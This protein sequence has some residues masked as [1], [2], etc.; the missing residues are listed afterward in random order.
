MAVKE[1]TQYHAGKIYP[2]PIETGRSYGLDV[3]QDLISR[4]EDKDAVDSFDIPC[5]SREIPSGK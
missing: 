4:S 2:K 1:R 3:V 5:T